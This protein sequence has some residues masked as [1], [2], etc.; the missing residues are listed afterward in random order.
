MEASRLA[1]AALAR[2][3]NIENGTTGTSDPRTTTLATSLGVTFNG[4]LVA[5]NTTTDRVSTNESNITALQGR[6]STNESNITALQGRVSTNESNI[7]ALQTAVSDLQALLADYANHTHS[8]IDTTI[9][10]TA[11]GSG[12]ATDTSKTTDGVV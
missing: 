11:D 5:T 8:Y 9:A 4:N 12:I 3:S 2:T 6:V 10:D 7:T 1:R